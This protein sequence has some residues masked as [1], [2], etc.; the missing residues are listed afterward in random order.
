[1]PDYPGMEVVTRSEDSQK[2]LPDHMMMFEEDTERVEL[3][4][5]GK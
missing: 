1:M 3:G 5:K 4:P 2:V